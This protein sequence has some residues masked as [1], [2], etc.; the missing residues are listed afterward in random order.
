LK[1]NIDLS[2]YLSLYA[3]ALDW[4]FQ[5][6]A[7]C[8]SNVQLEELL[9][10]CKD[11]KNNSL[12]FLT[13]LHSFR[14][15]FITSRAMD[16][17]KVIADTNNEG[18]TTGTLFRQLGNII[19]LFPPPLDERV[20][21]FNEAWKSISTITNISDY[22][23]CIEMWSIFIANNFDIS[24]LNS[25][26]GDIVTRIT[27]KRAFEKHYTELQGIIDKVAS[28]IKD[29]HGFLSMDNFLPAL[30]LF[31]K[32]S[33]KFDVCKNILEKYKAYCA[34]D[35]SD[36]EN[37]LMMINDPVTINAFMC[38]AKVLNDGVK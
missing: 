34:S 1:Q 37:C 36:N 38:I 13:L 3:P 17:V 4:I 10:H 28:N 7:A 6:Y 19:S 9:N 2:V 30:D 22:M 21:T 25:F 31:Q 26:F 33:I 23:Q 5:N 14:P 27:Q 24:T 15:E 12:L 35:E 29:F 8:A 16:F 18:I 20:K 11:K 32:E